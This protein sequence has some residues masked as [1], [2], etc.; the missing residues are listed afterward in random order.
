MDKPQ[1]KI[2]LSDERGC[3][4]LEW[5]RS[6]NTFNFG[7]YKNDYKQPFGCLYVLNDDT[8]AGGSSL[9]LT[10]EEPTTVML[11]PVVGSLAYKTST[12]TEG[13]VYPGEMQL[14]H[15]DKDAEL[16][17][18]NP[19]TD[20]L[21]NFL[22]LWF[23]NDSTTSE[24]AQLFSFDLTN[25]NVL[26]PVATLETL[27]V[28]IGKFMGRHEALYKMRSLQSG[29]FV[30]VIEGAFEV[31]GRLLHPRDGLALWNEAADIELEAL[32]NEAI[33]LLVELSSIE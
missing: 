11:L 33:I 26:V 4:Q 15:I 16:T 17:L 32:S 25:K 1:G 31:H 29:L 8:L 14:L 12:E 27:V 28:S 24:D 5:F 6:Y 13:I 21:I 10:I 3:T 18:T 22:Q 30:F 19:H 7:N 20:E 23:K 9:K 2:F